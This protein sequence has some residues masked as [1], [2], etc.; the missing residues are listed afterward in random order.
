MLEW[1]FKKLIVFFFYFPLLLQR[2]A[3]LVYF[4][5]LLQRK[6]TKRKQLKEPLLRK[7]FFEI[8][9][10]GRGIRARKG[11]NAS[12]HSLSFLTL[13]PSC[14]LCERTLRG[15]YCFWG[16]DTGLLNP[17]SLPQDH[18]CRRVIGR[19]GEEYH[20]TKKRP[21]NELAGKPNSQ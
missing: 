13:T 8:S 18:L 14:A 5:L 20:S 7:G 16:L 19:C 17:S 11:A 3:A 10:K 9:P 15:G 1:S 21:W 6:G 4:S 2:K 12:P